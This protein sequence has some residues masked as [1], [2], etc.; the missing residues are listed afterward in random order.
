M[1]PWTRPT[2]RPPPLTALSAAAA[3]RAA[4]AR[5]FTTTP[6]GQHARDLSAGADTKPM[7]PLNEAGRCGVYAHRPMICRLHGIPHELHPPGRAPQAPQLGPGCAEF[8]RLCG[9]A[10]YHPF[11]RTPLYAELARLES[12]FQ[13]A[14]GPRRKIRMTIAEMLL[15]DGVLS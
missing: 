1:P 11:D 12:E 3:R 14:L 15:D 13:Q 10:V 5:G 9:R 8:H 6:C 2:G 4:A 7:C